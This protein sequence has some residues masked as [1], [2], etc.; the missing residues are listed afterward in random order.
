MIYKS[1]E[2]SVPR[3][4]PIPRGWF[5]AAENSRYLLI[6]TIESSWGECWREAW[7]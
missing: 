5:I 7:S 6:A 1:P 3:G 4:S 2:Y